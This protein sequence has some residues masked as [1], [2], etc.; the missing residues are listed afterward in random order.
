MSTAS[1][2]PQNIIQKYFAPLSKNQRRNWWIL[3]ILNVLF[4]LIEILFAG[5]AFVAATL[6]FL[7]GQVI[8]IAYY[9]YFNASKPKKPWRDWVDAIGFAVVA[10]SIVRAVFLE[11]FTI[12]TPSMEKSLLVG[13]FLF[14]SKFHYGPRMPMSP[15]SVP[16]THHTMPMTTNTPSYSR[17]I[18]L[19]YYRLPG[20]SKVNRFDP[21][22]F[23]WPADTNPRP[24]DKKENYIKRCIGLPG[25]RLKIIQGNVY[26]N[27]QKISNPEESMLRY[28]VETNGIG[29][30]SKAL[31]DI[32]LN[33]HPGEFG[34]EG[35]GR[36]DDVIQIG[37]TQFSIFMTVKQKAVVEKMSHVTS[38][39]PD[40]QMGV[41]FHGEMMFPMGVNTGWSRDNYGELWIPAE[42]AKIPMNDSL[43]AMYGETIRKFEGVTSF[44]KKNGQ[45]LLEGKPITEYTFRQNY[46]W[47]MGD[48]R[49][50]SLDSRF[51][52]FVPEDHVVGKA[53]FIWMSMDSWGKWFGKIRWNR[54]FHFAD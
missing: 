44:E 26:I 53:V 1:E 14:V 37:Q 9:Y 13:D 12:P 29:F 54:L 11:A 39:V 19:P 25:D 34:Q 23:N 28:I 27:G 42:G 24:I 46:Y 45:Y 10:A 16:F 50:N 52:G 51:W 18:E 43:F 6:L 36:Y 41:S 20:F 32:G 4:Y 30:D 40:L 22:V 47:M 21:V 15:L 48:N 49:H 5:A 33:Y 8:L 38:I 3:T 7:L 31:K 2:T 17:A 35:M